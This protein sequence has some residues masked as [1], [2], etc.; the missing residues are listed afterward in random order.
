MRW[1]LI[2][3][4]QAYRVLISPWKPRCCRFDPTC[5][6]Y[7]IDALRQHGA[8]RGL[9][10]TVGRLLRCQPFAEPGYDPVPPRAL[11]RKHPR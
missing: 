8:R 9:W 4:V 3:L 1:L 11:G 6:H 7:A 2:A 10:L 5:S